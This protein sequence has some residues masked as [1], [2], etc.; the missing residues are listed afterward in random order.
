MNP[1]A[2]VRQFVTGVPVYK[3]EADGADVIAPSTPGP[4]RRSPST[5][6]RL[7]SMWTWLGDDLGVEDTATAPQIMRRRD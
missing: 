1:D 5:C 6:W 4:P 3:Q 7:K 2:V